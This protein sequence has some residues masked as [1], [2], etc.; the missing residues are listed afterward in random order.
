M[1]P[2]PALMTCRA[3]AR[4]VMSWGADD[5]GGDSDH[6]IQQRPVLIDRPRGRRYGR[7]DPHGRKQDAAVLA[8]PGTPWPS[9]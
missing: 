8:V 5:Q 3:V 9:P 1:T 2:E 4:A 7:S 6:M